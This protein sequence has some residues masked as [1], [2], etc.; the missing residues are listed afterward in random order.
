MKLI[1]TDDMYEL[2]EEKIRKVV[3]VGKNFVPHGIYAIEKDG[4]IEM[5][6]EHY[7]NASDLSDAIDDYARN[8]FKVYFNGGSK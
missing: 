2:D 3:N 7:D 6:N 5:K 4:I 8:G 1:I